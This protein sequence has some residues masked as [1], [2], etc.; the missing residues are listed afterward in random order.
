MA[1]TEANGQVRTRAATYQCSC[2]TVINHYP[3]SPQAIMS[4]PP[5]QSTLRSNLDS[6]FN[7]ALQTY[8]KK[9]GKDIASHPLATELQSCDSPNAILVVLRRQVPSLDRSKDSDERIAKCLVPI[10]NVVYTFSATLGEGVGLVIITILSLRRFCTLTAASK[11]FSPAKIIFSGIGVLLL[12]GHFHITLWPT[13]T[14]TFIRRLKMSPQA[15][16]LSLICS[17]GSN[18]SFVVSRF[19]P[20]C[21]LRLP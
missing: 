14:C 12:V 7:S 9:T 21:H 4:S 19:T 6:I 15:K 20:A 3:H 2:S 16:T 8:K 17:I 11:V 10:I 1:A 5:S 13:L 18:T